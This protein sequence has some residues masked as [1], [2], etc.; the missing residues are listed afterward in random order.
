MTRFEAYISSEAEVPQALNWVTSAFDS[1]EIQEPKIPS[2]ITQPYEE[3]PDFTG[4]TK[5]LEMIHSILS[6][7]RDGSAKQRIFALTG[8]GGVGKTQ[9][10]LNYVFSHRDVYPIILFAHA[11][12]QAK[13]SESFCVFATELGLCNPESLKPQ[14]AIQAVKDCLKRTGML[15][16]LQALFVSSQVLALIGRFR[17]RL[18]H[19][20]R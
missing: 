3:N 12:S 5:T 10:A 6:P 9:T 20:H 17:G 18:A 11:D 8:L 4:R 16:T 15:S 13:L 14:I 19:G 1:P 7:S 2:C